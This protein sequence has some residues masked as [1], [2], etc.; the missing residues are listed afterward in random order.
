MI[1]V[2]LAD[3]FNTSSS[4][5]RQTAASPE[6][7]E[8]IAIDPSTKKAPAWSCPNAAIVSPPSFFPHFP[9]TTCFISTYSFMYCCA[10][11]SNSSS[12]PSLYAA[13][14]LAPVPEPVPPISSS[15]D[16]SVLT[17]W[18]SGS[19]PPRMALLRTLLFWDAAAARVGGPLTSRIALICALRSRDASETCT[20][21]EGFCFMFHAHFELLL[22]ALSG[23]GVPG[24]RVT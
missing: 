9:E 8:W 24:A 15:L 21:I 6:Q 18:V 5:S 22:Q 11:V 20:S 19:L 12:S 4:V 16:P 10:I 3:P 17:A 2:A 1:C 13:A 7:G 23:F 14:S